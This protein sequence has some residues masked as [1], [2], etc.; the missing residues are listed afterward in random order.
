MDNVGVWF[1]LVVV[2]G[3]S[4]VDIWCGVLL[5]IWISLA[6]E[7]VERMAKAVRGVIKWRIRWALPDKKKNSVC[8]E[9]PLKKK[10]ELIGIM[11]VYLS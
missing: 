5:V 4:D 11:F 7:I 10:G 6:N 9:E 2:V 1:Y 8:N 3:S